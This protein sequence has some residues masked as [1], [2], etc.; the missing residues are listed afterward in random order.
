L[1]ATAPALRVA[2]VGSGFSGVAVAWQLLGRLPAGSRVTMVNGSG[3]FARGL[4]YGTQ[5]ADHLLNV[6]AGRMSLDPAQ[7]DHFVQW[8]RR[9]GG[10]HANADGHEFVSRRRYGDYLQASLEARA[11]ARPD[12]TLHERVATVSDAVPDGG[13]WRLGFAD[14][15]AQ[16]FDAVVL[17]LG[18]LAPRPPHPD[19][20]GLTGYAGDPWAEAALAG[21]EAHA[22]LALI[23]SGLTMLDVLISLRA[24]GHVGPVLALS[25]RGLLPQGHRRNEGPPQPWTLDPTIATARPLRQQLRRFRAEI[26]RA[27]A[28]GVDWRDVWAAF[29]AATPQA[30][31]ALDARS[32]SQFLRHL[33][34]Y[35][36]V[37]R[38]RAAPE[39]RVVLEDDLA[40][41]R[42]KHAAGRIVAVQSM[43]HGLGLRWRP[44]G[45]SDVETFVATRIINCS[46]PS[47]VID[48][49]SSPLLWRLRQSGRLQ[50]CPHGLGLLVDDAYQ[51]IDAQGQ[52][53]PGLH[54]IGPHLRAQRWEATAV[55]ELRE[56]AAQLAAQLL[57]R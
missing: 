10:D 17:A 26:A 43:P 46:G 3:R 16:T 39:A 57:T 19:L 35:W 14:G 30:W 40:R 21:L 41:E 27:R 22:P 34:P 32:R 8:L 36:D 50:A 9:R 15:S 6:P 53:Q 25:R 56:H 4:A 5:S 55:P 37:H 51:L 45:R 44:R 47:S 1:S 31:Q 11:A 29:R 2:I 13:G 42:L 18:H 54:Y 52:G 48:A 33:L 12:V 28:Q 24:R 38:H 23:G 20:V 49:A 7:P